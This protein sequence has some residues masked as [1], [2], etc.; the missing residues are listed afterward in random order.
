MKGAPIITKLRP[1]DLET[2]L[3]GLSDILTATVNAGASVG[4]ILPH[5]DDKS[6]Q[7]WSQAVFP[8]VRTGGRLLL[9]ARAD[10][11]AA[12][13]VQLLTDL[14]ENQP[15]RAEVAKLLVHPDFRRV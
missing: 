11:H 4:F 8:A 12:G 2:N 5:G 15:H 10:G 3:P 7:F 14:P 9:L 1:E 6:R 13:T